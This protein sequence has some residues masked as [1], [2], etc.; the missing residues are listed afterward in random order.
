MNYEEALEKLK[1]Y[2]Q[3]HVLTY[4]EE[5][6]GE[7]KALLLS[8]I[9]TTDFSMLA[10]CRNREAAAGRGVISPLAAM[11]L[12]EIREKKEKFTALGLEAIRAGKV[13]AVLLAGGMGT[14]LGSD[15]PKGMYN[16]GISK[17]VYIFQRLIENLLDV[18][19]QAESWIPLYIMTSDKNH[20]ATTGFLK[21]HDYFGYKGEYVTFFTQEMAP[22]SDYEGR[23]YMEE[24]GKISTSPNGNGGWYSSMYK[25][26]IAQKAMADGVEWL[27]VF[28]V[29]N[30][31]QRI[32]DPCFV[33]AVIDAGCAAGAKVVRKCAPDEKVGV[34]CLEDGK[35][36]IIEYYELTEDLANARDENGDPAYYFGVILN[37]LFRIEDL[38]KIREKN[39]PLHIVEKKIPYINEAGEHIKPETPNG[40]KFEQLVLDMIHELDSCLP[41]EVERNKEFAPIKNKTGVDSVESARALC[42][43]NGIEL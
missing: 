32:A 38:E 12:P 13:G 22:A 18:V 40:Y 24:K 26:G 37:Y 31:L 10:S 6:S 33:G 17:D 21:E 1:L 36:S 39:L 43:E 19:R 7:E 27:N 14:R 3:E 5:L 11:Q 30:V 9:E 28:A 20:E 4:Y 41:F 34:M 35:P 15:D 2:G 23:V 25:W 8:Q 16:I 29:D 42:R